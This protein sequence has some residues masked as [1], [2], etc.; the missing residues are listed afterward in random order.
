MS[1]SVVVLKEKPSDLYIVVGRLRRVRLPTS[2]VILKEK[3]VNLGRLGPDSSVSLRV[4]CRKSM[5]LDLEN[6][7][8]QT[9]Q[10]DI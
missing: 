7:L 4:L 8:V 6:S 3:I 9:I 2:V 10:F 1:T 5:L